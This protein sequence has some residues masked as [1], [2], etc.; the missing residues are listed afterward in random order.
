MISSN[1]L[2]IGVVELSELKWL[3]PN[4]KN[5]LLEEVLP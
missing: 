5:W 3:D 1:Q 2:P 4:P